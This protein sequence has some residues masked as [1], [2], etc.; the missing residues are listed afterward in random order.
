VL[1]II[2]THKFE[3]YIIVTNTPEL[4]FNIT[5]D[6]PNVTILTA[7]VEN[8]FEKFDTY[9]YTPTGIDGSIAQISFDCSPRF[10]AECKYYNKNVIYHNID[11][12]YLSVDTGLKWRRHD[13]ENSFEKLYLNDSDEIIDILYDRL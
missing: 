9:I 8:I 11:E 6:F 3:K 7:P 10:I 4:Y 5:K 12:K 2:F 1:D 13:I